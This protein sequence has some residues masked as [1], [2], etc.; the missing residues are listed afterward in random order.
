VDLVRHTITVTTTSLSV[1]ALGVE[2]GGLQRELSVSPPLA[3]TITGGGT[4]ASG[5]RDACPLGPG[6]VFTSWSEDST[7]VSSSPSYTFTAQADR[8][9][10]ANFASAGGNVTIATTS[11][12]AHGGSTLGDGAYASGANATV[13]AIPNTGYKF[14][15]WQINGVTVSTSR[16]NTFTATTNCVLAAKFKPV[17]SVEVS[18]DPPTGGEV[19]ADP[20]YEVGELARLKAKPQPGWCFVNWTQNGLP[21]SADA[22]MGNV[23]DGRNV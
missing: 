4:Y 6:Y 8:A 7:G 5:A 17:Y 9:L 19:E 10:V 22:W 21:V 18:A 3:R 2:G 16:T 13:I 11:L 14:S 15:K 12:P 1:F 23:G 20:V